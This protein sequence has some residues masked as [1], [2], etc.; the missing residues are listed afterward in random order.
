MTILDKI[1][2]FLGVRSVLSSIDKAERQKEAEEE[3][4]RNEREWEE[5]DRQDRISKLESDIKDLNRRIADLDMENSFRD[6]DIYQDEIDDLND[7]VDDLG[8]ELD[9]LYDE[10]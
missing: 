8:N 9:D 2:V 7:Q 10:Y 3:R 5:L 6:D 4:L 1:L